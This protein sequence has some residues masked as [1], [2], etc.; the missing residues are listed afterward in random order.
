MM[1][2]HRVIEAM[3]K[4]TPGTHPPLREYL[5]EEKIDIFADLIE[6]AEKFDFG[7][8]VLERK[9]DSILPGGY[10]YSLPDF[11]DTEW[12]LW[13]LGLIPLPANPSWYEYQLGT[14]RSGLLVY[15]HE[16]RWCV[17]RAELAPSMYWDAVMVSIPRKSAAHQTYTQCEMHSDWMAP[18]Q[19]T[20]EQKRTLWGD[21]AHISIY[22]TL[23]LGSKTTEKKN[24]PAPAFINKARAKKGKPLLPE[25]TVVRIVPHQYITESQREAGRTHASPRLHWRRSHLRVYDRATPASTFVEGKGWCVAIPRCLVGVADQGEVHHEY[26]VRNET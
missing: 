21:Q 9:D 17:V 10:G 16:E 3:R 8:L 22:L 11:T 26:F 12:E 23:M 5:S 13:G 20:E 6:A 24:V 14:S 1:H 2:A 19:L 18:Q 7:P 4:R 25:H 15:T